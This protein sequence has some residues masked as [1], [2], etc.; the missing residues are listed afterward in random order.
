M[1][2]ARSRRPDVGNVGT[3]CD[4]THQVCAAVN[5]SWRPGTAAGVIRVQNTKGGR[6][7][8]KEMSQ[9]F[10]LNREIERDKARL[11]ELEAAA[12]GITQRITGLPGGGKRD[13][14]GQNCQVR[15]RDSRPKSHYRAQ[16]TALL[17]RA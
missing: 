7:T 14:R 9:L 3:G 1:Y 8:K 17:V 10:H 4:L 12:T 6:M 16:Y 2:Q 11:A 5:T 13:P 15:L